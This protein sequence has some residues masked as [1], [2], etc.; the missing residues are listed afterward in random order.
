MF[1]C[2]YIYRERGNDS[3][4]GDIACSRYTAVT[5]QIKGFVERNRTFVVTGIYAVRCLCPRKRNCTVS[6]TSKCPSYTSTFI[7]PDCCN[8]AAVN[9]DSV[10]TCAEIP[11]ANTRCPCAAR[12]VDNAAVYRNDTRILPICAADS[13]RTIDASRWTGSTCYS[14]RSTVNYYSSAVVSG[15][16]ANTRR[17]ATVIRIGDRQCPRIINLPVDSQCVARIHADTFRDIEY[18]AVF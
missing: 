6:A 9:G 15:V 10:T 1:R 3:L 13:R 17:I 8:I 16:S 12:S 11:T 7:S 5:A 4:A 14:N 18:S 2:V